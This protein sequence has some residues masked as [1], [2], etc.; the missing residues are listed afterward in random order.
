[1]QIKVNGTQDELPAQSTIRDLLKS[2][3]IG[4]EIVIVFVNDELTRREAWANTSLRS[5]DN[6]EIVKVVGGG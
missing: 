4:E 2:R 1:M 3:T 5:G 6:V